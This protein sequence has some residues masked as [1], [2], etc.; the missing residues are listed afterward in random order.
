MVLAG[1]GI[2]DIH[3]LNIDNLVDGGSRLK[4]SGRTGSDHYIPLGG[5]VRSSLMKWINT[6]SLLVPPSA[7]IFVSVHWSR[8]R[9]EPGRRLSKRGIGQIIGSYLRDIGKKTQGSCARTLKKTFISLFLDEGADSLDLVEIMHMHPK[10]ARAFMRVS[11]RG[12]LHD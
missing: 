9:G 7:A 3:N 4:L 12:Q 10:T 6:R 2:S 8:A 5:F 11:Q 1:L